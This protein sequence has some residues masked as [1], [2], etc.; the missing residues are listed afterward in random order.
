MKLS[1][2]TI[3]A[4]YSYA[5]TQVNLPKEVGDK[6]ISWGKKNIKDE[7][8]YEDEEDDSKGREDMPHCTILY[9]LTSDNPEPVKKL[10]KE[11]RPIKATLGKVSLFEQD[12]YDVVKINVKSPDLHRLHKKLSDNLNNENSFP[13]YKP[14]VTIAYVKPGKGKKYSGNKEFEGIELTFDTVR[15][16]SKKEKETYIKLKNSIAAELSWNV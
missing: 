10:L 15:F 16:S 9:G 12:D 6:I 2:E 14:H 1:W 13:T 3:E 4:D 7:D 5:S 11:E 8:I